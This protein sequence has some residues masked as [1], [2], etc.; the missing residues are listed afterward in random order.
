M[1]NRSDWPERKIVHSL[2][3]PERKNRVFRVPV[4]T[5]LFSH[6]QK[7]GDALWLL[8]WLVD[9]TTKEVLRDG[10]TFG[11][12][13]GGRPIR[14]ADPAAALGCHVKTVRRW[15]KRLAEGGYVEIKRTPIGYRYQV[16]NS[17]KW[18]SG[19]KS[20]LSDRTKMSTRLPETVTLSA[21]NGQSTARNG[22][23]NIDRT[24]TEEHNRSTTATAAA[25]ADDLSYSAFKEAS[26]AFRSLTD[27]RFFGELTS[28]RA[29]WAEFVTGVGADAAA[30][31]VELWA[32]SDEDF[33]RIR[34]PLAIFL[35]QSAE[36]GRRARAE[37][38]ERNRPKE[39]LVD[40]NGVLMTA[41]E[42]ARWDCIEAEDNERYAER[43]KRYDA[44]FPEASV[45]GIV[46]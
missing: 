44:E 38:A 14:D 4:S 36:W 45:E 25:A 6:C 8:V 19:Q 11:F 40:R 46:Q 28:K 18:P 20:P 27:G 17:E 39:P 24:T 34:Y 13:L 30:L 32:G 26:M 9:K 2:T 21:R 31:A 10:R 42:K 37:I 12:V 3:D 16:I 23:S 29:E 33:T 7:I 41:K 35:R 22:N 5:S 1:G 15:R 43:R